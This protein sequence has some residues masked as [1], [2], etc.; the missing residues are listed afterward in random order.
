[1]ID[2]TVCIV[3]HKHRDLLEPLLSSIH[4][5]TRHVSYEVFVV[6]NASGDGSI[7]MVKAR[8]PWVYLI[9]NERPQGFA[10]N[11]NQV[12]RQGRG[13]YFALLNDDMLLRNDAFDRMVAFMDAK[14]E[15]GAVGCK[16]LNGDGTLQRSCWRGFPS[17]RTLMIDL[18]Y[19]S[20]WLPQLPWVRD[21]EGILQNASEPLQVDYVLGACLVVR[22]QVVDQVGLLDESFFMFLEETDWCYRI[23]EKG[24]RIYWMPDGEIIHYGQQ[25]VSKDPQRFIPMLYR[26]YCRFSRKHGSRGAQMAALKVVLATGLIVRGALWAYRSLKGKTNG[27]CMLE[28]Y[29]Q[30]LRGLPSF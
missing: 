19:L 10:A 20:K 2:L 29:L 22:R 21:F 16:L 1:M 23:K 5:L 25:S 6:D 28:G 15:V 27:R 24:W 4:A 13:R 9:C 12:L 26:N 8:F 14:P 11:S 17:P 7:E 30:A 18:F 3:N